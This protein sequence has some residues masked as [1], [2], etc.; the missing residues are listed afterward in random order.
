VAYLD[1]QQRRVAVV[2]FIRPFLVVAGVA[3][4][5]VAVLN[6]EANKGRTATEGVTRVVQSTGKAE[7]G[8]G[9]NRGTRVSVHRI[10][11]AA[12]SS[13]R[14]QGVTIAL[15]AVGG[16]LLLAA[17]L[18][19]RLSEFRFGGMTIKLLDPDLFRRLR[20][21]VSDPDKVLQALEL[22][23]EKV[24][25]APREGGWRG[26]TDEA[27]ESVIGEVTFTPEESIEVQDGAAVFVDGGGSPKEPA[28]R[29]TTENQYLP[30]G[31]FHEKFVRAMN[32]AVEQRHA[33]CLYVLDREMLEVLA[34][35]VFELPPG[36]APILLDALGT[37]TDRKDLKARCLGAALIGTR[38]LHHAAAMLGRRSG[39][40]FAT[41]DPGHVELA[42]LT[43]LGFK[44][45]GQ[46]ETE[47]LPAGEYWVQSPMLN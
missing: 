14:S 20:S 8:G 44:L 3:V 25:Q 17:A 26:L 29:V 22:L 46:E 11:E 19:D 40:F 15:I 38:Y 9:K 24:Q 42:N 7:N 18:W 41:N 32:R 43:E 45:A 5:L 28:L 37:R 10:S 21:R 36:D 6:W 27:I 2:K 12:G 16:A 13:L 35:L 39:L 47:G 30:D 1:A 23:S 4:L 33:Q 31:Q 34:V